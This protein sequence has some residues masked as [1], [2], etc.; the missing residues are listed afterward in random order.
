[1]EIKPLEIEN[2]PSTIQIK[3][4]LTTN[5]PRDVR[6]FAAGY[7]GPV[8]SLDGFTGFWKDDNDYAF[9][10]IKT[11]EIYSLEI[12]EIRNGS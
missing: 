5:N 1:M 8:E 11:E 12:L 4:R 9:F 3:I 7:F 2:N 10:I 6:T